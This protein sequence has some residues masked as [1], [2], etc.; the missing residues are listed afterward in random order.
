MIQY[1]ANNII[2]RNSDPRLKDAIGKKVYVGYSSVHVLH[3]AEND[4]MEY[5]L[6]HVNDGDCPPFFV[7]EDKDGN[8]HE[9]TL[10]I[11][12]KDSTDPVYVPFE[13][14]YEFVLACSSHTRFMK[15]YGSW[16][17]CSLPY[18]GETIL[19]LVTGVC[20]D[21]VVLEGS[22]EIVRWEELLKRFSFG[23]GTPCGKIAEP[24]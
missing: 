8:K 1:I 4:E 15:T 21:G 14:L 18:S 9:S 24:D 22:E 19:A 23:D 3:N 10:I 2:S 5:T 6:T 17:L 12:K 11:L 7:V 13:N 20:D 16:I